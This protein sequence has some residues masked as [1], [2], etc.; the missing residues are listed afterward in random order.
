MFEDFVLR[1]SLLA[2]F[3]SVVAFDLA[4]FDLAEF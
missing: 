3:S 2:F 4:V 1:L